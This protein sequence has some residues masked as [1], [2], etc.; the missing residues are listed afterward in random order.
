M[1]AWLTAMKPIGKLVKFIEFSAQVLRYR[2]LSPALVLSRSGVET[3]STLYNPCLGSGDSVIDALGRCCLSV[4]SVHL[5]S[6]DTPHVT[7]QLCHEMYT[8]VRRTS[9][10][11]FCWLT[12]SGAIRSEQIVGQKSQ[13]YPCQ[14]AIFGCEL[15]EVLCTKKFLGTRGTYLGHS[16]SGSQIK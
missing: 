3:Y 10:Q 13:C 7:A 14:I 4:R 12:A 5:N 8:I 9:R 11:A 1:T 15:T 16:C 2:S 6:S